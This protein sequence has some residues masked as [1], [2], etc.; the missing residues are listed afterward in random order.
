MSRIRLAPSLCQGVLPTNI[1]AGFPFIIAM[2]CG[3]VF[4]PCISQPEPSASAAP[5]FVPKHFEKCARENVSNQ[6]SQR[7][8]KVSHWRQH[9]HVSVRRGSP[10]S[11]SKSPL[12]QRRYEPHL[13][14]F[15]GAFVRRAWRF[16]VF[17]PDKV[18]SGIHATENP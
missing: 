1:I 6:F 14:H 8:F 17:A 11:S 9:E 5:V 16:V 18:A 13:R 12:R 10:A 15:K 4:L 3:M 7:T 2:L